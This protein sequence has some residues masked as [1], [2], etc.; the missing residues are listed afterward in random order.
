MVQ[1][2]TSIEDCMD[3][4]VLCLSLGSGSTATCMLCLCRNFLSC[5]VL[6]SMPF[7]VICEKFRLLEEFADGV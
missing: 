1:S 3:L 2:A 7:M 6:L 4:N 5:C